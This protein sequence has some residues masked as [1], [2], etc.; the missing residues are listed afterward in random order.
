MEQTAGPF[1]PN[2]RRVRRKPIPRK[3]FHSV[4][5]WSNR[6]LES[7]FES[8]DFQLHPFG[9][10]PP[11]E[12]KNGIMWKTKSK[13]AL[14]FRSSREALGTKQSEDALGMK[15]AYTSLDQQ[16]PHQDCQRISPELSS[17]KQ[18]PESRKIRGLRWLAVCFAIYSANFLYGLDTT[19]VANI[20]PSIVNS[21]GHIGELAW[22]G[23]GFP[24][25]SVAMIMPLGAAYGLFD[26]K[27]LFLSS[28]ALFEAGSALC[29]GAPNMAALIVGRGKI[30]GDFASPR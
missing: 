10:W 3:E 26:T 5:E 2:P 13:E 16:P 6:L 22:I 28:I 17:E 24:L 11:Q 8:D 19:I 20:Q 14:G 23:V 1:I 9:T 21:L 18:E 7:S 30:L 12:R 4:D 27:V 15:Q 29:G 25:G